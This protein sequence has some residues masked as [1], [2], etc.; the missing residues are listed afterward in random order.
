VYAVDNAV[1][2]DTRDSFE[3]AVASKDGDESNSSSST[4]NNSLYAYLVELENFKAQRQKEEAEREQLRKELDRSDKLMSD[5]MK[6][7]DEV[8][9]KQTLDETGKSRSSKKSIDMDDPEFET[10]IKRIARRTFL[11]EAAQV[12]MLNKN[13]L[14]ESINKLQENHV[15][16]SQAAGD[17]AK[18]T[19]LAVLDVLFFRRPIEMLEKLARVE[20]LSLFRD[21]PKYCIITTSGDHG[22]EGPDGNEGRDGMSGGDSFFS[23]YCDGIVTFSIMILIAFQVAPEV[24]VP[25]ARLDRLELQRSPTWCPC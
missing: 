3:T 9:A 1:D 22:P 8:K 10:M 20:V 4:G 14:A 15:D 13:N 21:L 16:P 24:T 12:P 25:L 7:L 17:I 5:V 2:P 11:D 6:Q 19:L 23:T 18:Q